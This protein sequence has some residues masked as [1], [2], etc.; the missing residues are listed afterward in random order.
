MKKFLGLAVLALAAVPALVVAAGHP[1]KAGKWKISIET[2]MPGLPAGVKI[3]A[4]VTEVCI[5]EADLAKDPAKSVQSGGA[6]DCKVS[7]YKIDGNKVSWK[8][9]C[10]SSN[11]KGTGEMTYS[12]DSYS[13]LMKMTVGDKSITS[14]H[15]GTWVGACEKK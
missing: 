11:T 13:G 15:S 9:E 3:P 12:G 2:E 1:Q 8:M 7:D 14:K 5:T 10:P 4:T 6:S